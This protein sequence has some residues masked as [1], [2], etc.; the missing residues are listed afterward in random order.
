MRIAPALRGSTTN[1]AF[2]ALF[3]L[4]CRLTPAPRTMTV[5]PRSGF[6][7]SPVTVTIKAP[8]RPTTKRIRVAK[9]R[10]AQRAV[11]GWNVPVAVGVVLVVD[12][13]EVDAFG[14][15]FGGVDV[16]LVLVDVGVEVDVEVG[17]DV[18][19]SQSP[20]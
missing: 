9:S 11:G 18:A 15:A 3:V 10:T 17:V 7:F 19:A 13:V 2:P 8:R 12:D 6:P 4:A 1:R 20:L 5:T 16:V 14:G